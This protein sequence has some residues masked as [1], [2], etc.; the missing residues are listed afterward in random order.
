[1]LFYEAPISKGGKLHTV[2]LDFTYDG[3]GLGKPGT[4]K[5]VIDGQ[6]V[7]E[8]RIERTIPFRISADE[9]LDIGED[10]GTPVSEDYQ[11]PFKFTGNLKKL[12]IQ[13]TD[14]TFTAEEQ[15]E[16]ETMRATI[17]LSD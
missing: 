16:I 2:V 9:T 4:A 14:A 13:L 10:T 5:L 3:G 12:A 11:V 15:A 7:A 8:G 17:G 1:M 6:Q